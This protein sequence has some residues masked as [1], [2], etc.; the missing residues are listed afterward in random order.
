MKTAAEKA[1]NIAL[2]VYILQAVSFL[3]GITALIAL[4][5]N[6]VKQFDAQQTW[7]ASHFKWQIRTFWYGLL[8]MVLGILTS[9]IGIGY[10]ILM[11]NVLWIIYRIVKGG[12]NLNDEKPMYLET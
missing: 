8:W 4:I 10:F 9:F 5:I 3:T 7:V 1:K 11:A 2:V 6:Y 12:L